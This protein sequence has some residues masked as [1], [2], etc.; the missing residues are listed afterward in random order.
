[1]DRIGRY[2]ATLGV[3]GTLAVGVAAVKKAKADHFPDPTP[4]WKWVDI[5]SPNSP[6]LDP[7]D[8]V[9]VYAGD[10]IIG[11]LKITVDNQIK[12]FL[13]AYGDS[14]PNDGVQD[15]AYPNQIMSLK[16]WKNYLKQE[17]N[18]VTN[19]N[20][21]RWTET[22]DRIQVDVAKGELVSKPC[23]GYDLNGDGIANFGD[24]AELANWWK[25]ECGS[26]NN[27][28]DFCDGGIEGSGYGSRDGIVDFLDVARFTEHWLE[29][30][31]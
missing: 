31:P 23:G 4:T 27:W 30:S 13:H 26:S 12:P 3:I 5:Y 17:F 25:G 10:L 19:P 6:D 1:M 29:E 22:Y 9:A 16:I 11:K 20:E 24:F 14:D 21:V 15:G 8:E 7:N 18:A 2:L 28:C